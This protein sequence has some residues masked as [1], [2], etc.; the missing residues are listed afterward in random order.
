MPEK[1]TTN[2]LIDYMFAWRKIVLQATTRTADAAN[3]AL[4]QYCLHREANAAHRL[5]ATIQD[6]DGRSVIQC[7]VRRERIEV[8]A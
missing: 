3:G 1:P 6:F 7:A 4:H 5:Q 8:A 2:D